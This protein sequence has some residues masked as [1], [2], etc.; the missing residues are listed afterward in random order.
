[1]SDLLLSLQ[2]IQVYHLVL[3]YLVHHH[4]EDL[5]EIDQVA[6]HQMT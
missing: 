1:M 6:A 5:I 3:Q 2:V 4:V